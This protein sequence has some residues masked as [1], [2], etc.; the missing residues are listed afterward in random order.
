MTCDISINCCIQKRWSFSV[1][2]SLQLDGPD[3]H[4]IKENIDGSI[5][6][7]TNSSFYLKG[8]CV[9]E[10]HLMKEL[11]FT[12]EVNHYTHTHDFN[13]HPNT[14]SQ[15]LMNSKLLLAPISMQLDRFR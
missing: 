14:Q 5:D 4:W 15:Y 13:K 12:N 9:C 10:M 6:E 8:S 11:P 3:P 2:R 7:Y 1:S